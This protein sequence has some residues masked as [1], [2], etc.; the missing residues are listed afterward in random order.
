MAVSLLPL[1]TTVVLMPFHKA[2]FISVEKLVTDE[3]V[4]SMYD[5]IHDQCMKVL[6]VANVQAKQK[7]A[8]QRQSTIQLPV[9]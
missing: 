5:C 3:A 6:V 9:C 7:A 4:K 1:H 8:L 2:R